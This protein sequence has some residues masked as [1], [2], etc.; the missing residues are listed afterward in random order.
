MLEF[1]DTA[2]IIRELLEKELWGD[3]DATLRG[4]VNSGQLDLTEM[5]E[6]RAQL[7]TVAKRMQALLETIENPKMRF[8]EV[9]EPFEFDFGM[10]E[11]PDDV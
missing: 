2:M 5:T 7:A 8:G 1:D 9:V 11:E 4:Q 6:L 3:E 10:D